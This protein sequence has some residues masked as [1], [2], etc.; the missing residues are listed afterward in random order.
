MPENKSI[1]A[2]IPQ[3][4]SKKSFFVR[5]YLNY[6][7]TW[8]NFNIKFPG[9]KYSGF[10]RVLSGVDIIKNRKIVIGN[11]VQLGKNT[12]I[13]TDVIIG[14][15]VLIAS[16]VSI[17]GKNDHLYNIAGKTMWDSP[18]GIDDITIIEDDVWL[19]TNAT[20]IAGVKV[21][22]GSIVAAGSLVVKDVPECEIWG[23]VPAKKIRDR[24]NDEADKQKHLDYLKTL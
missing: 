16:S 15:N 5:Y 4:M 12:V 24:F 20:I 3:G 14:N 8:Y 6:V 18:R 11:N 23:G 19:G 7:R 22:K 10:V 2:N 21:S 9:V 13:Y 17:I 1:Y